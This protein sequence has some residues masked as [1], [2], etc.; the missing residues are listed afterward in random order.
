MTGKYL[1]VKCKCGHEQKIFDR[2]T[3]EVKCSK[4][5]EILAHPMGGKAVIDAEIIEELE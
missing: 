1:K 2:A 3:T 5:S 4:C